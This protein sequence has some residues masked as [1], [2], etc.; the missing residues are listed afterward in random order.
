MGLIRKLTYVSTGGV[1]DVRS[2]AER[3]ASYSKKLLKEHEKADART[4]C[5]AP[6]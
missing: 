1:I 5:D 3:I 6:K 4:G 2:D